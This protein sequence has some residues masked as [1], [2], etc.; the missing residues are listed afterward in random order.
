M[1]ASAARA[2]VGHA[3]TDAGR[4]LS[5]KWLALNCEFRNKELLKSPIAWATWHLKAVPHEQL[6]ILSFGYDFFFFLAVSGGRLV[7][8][9]LFFIFVIYRAEI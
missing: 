6:Q 2:R 5:S 8:N 1:H 4:L 7:F 3:S 9:F